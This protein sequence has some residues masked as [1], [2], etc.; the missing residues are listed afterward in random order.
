MPG[1]E[2]FARTSCRTSL[3]TSVLVATIAIVMVTSV[4][5]RADCL[6]GYQCICPPTFTKGVAVGRVAARSEDAGPNDED[7]HLIVERVGGYMP[8]TAL[9]RVGDTVPIVAPGGELERSLSA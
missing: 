6:D 5:A 4:N 2:R 9:V 7:A 8:E 3:R 1:E